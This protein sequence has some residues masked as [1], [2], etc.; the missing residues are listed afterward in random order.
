[1]NYPPHLLPQQHFKIMH[2]EAWMERHFLLRHTNDKALIDPESGLLKL[3]YIVVNT[4][5][6]RDFSTNLLGV[7]TV[8]DCHWKINKEKMDSYY[9]A[10]WQEGEIVDVPLPDDCEYLIERGAFYIP[11]G[12]CAG[13]KIEALGS[14]P[15]TAICEVFHTPIRCNFW[16]FSLRWKDGN[17]D[18][19]NELHPKSIRNFFKSCVR[20]FIQDQAVFEVMECPTFPPDSYQYL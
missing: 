12:S 19:F 10:G 7:F 11:I 4:D 2:Y 16:H 5:H 18:Y 20:K 17:N 14:V 13:K 6:L 8:K 1:M 9:S 3:D 15:V